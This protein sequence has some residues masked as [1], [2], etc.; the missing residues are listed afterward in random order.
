MRRYCVFCHDEIVCKMATQVHKLTL[1][2][3]VF[4]NRF[5]YFA[6]DPTINFGTKNPK[7][8]KIKYLTN[9]IVFDEKDQNK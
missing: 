1:Q 5:F 8:S 4:L 6:P 2:V 3:R 9:A 7:L